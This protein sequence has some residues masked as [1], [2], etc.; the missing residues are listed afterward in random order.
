MPET[1]DDFVLKQTA[2]VTG[3]NPIGLISRDPIEMPAMY[4]LKESQRPSRLQ[5]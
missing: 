5:N 2:V 4:P 3:V 1:A